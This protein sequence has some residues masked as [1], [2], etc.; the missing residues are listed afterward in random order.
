MVHTAKQT[1]KF[2][3][4]AQIPV[5]EWPPQSPDLN[6]I[7]HYGTQ[8]T[9]DKNKYGTEQQQDKFKEPVPLFTRIMVECSP[10]TLFNLLQSMPSRINAV[11]QARNGH[12]P[13]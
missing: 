5:M 9:Y 7:E 12:T 10:D 6:P 11:I 13:Y 8:L 3:A 1:S 4:V 2:L